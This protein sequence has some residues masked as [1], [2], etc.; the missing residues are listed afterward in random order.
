MRLHDPR[1]AEDPEVPAHRV[2]MQLERVRQLLRVQAVAPAA[3]LLDDPASA[4]IGERVMETCFH[5]SDC[6]REYGEPNP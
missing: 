6:L 5:C 4:R 2:R 1:V 3:Q